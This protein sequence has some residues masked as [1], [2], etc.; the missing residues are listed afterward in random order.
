MTVSPAELLAATKVVLRPERFVLVGLEA[1]QLSPALVVLATD[2]PEFA[3]VVAE[4]DVTSLVVSEKVWNV[5]ADDFPNARIE[6]GYRVITFEQEMGWDIVGFLAHVTSLLANEGI[7]LGA[8]CGY[9]RDHL[10][11]HERYAQRAVQV[12]ERA[13]P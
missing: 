4:P 10:F 3:S 1:D 9:T 13:V 2:P 8:I 7:P 6:A 11:V 12:L 5:M